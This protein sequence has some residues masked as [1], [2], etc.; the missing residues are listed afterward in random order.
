MG[1]ILMEVTI[2]TDN[3]YSDERNEDFLNDYNYYSR[4]WIIFLKSLLEKDPNKR[5]LPSQIEIPKDFKFIK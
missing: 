1:S 2:G 5:P 4:E 3:F